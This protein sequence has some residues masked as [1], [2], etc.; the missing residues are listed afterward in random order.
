MDGISTYENYNRI[1]YQGWEAALYW[2]DRIGDLHY[3]VGGSLTT[4]RGKYLRYNENVVYDYQKVTGTATGS[5]RGYVCL[6]KFTSREEIETSPRQLF[7]DEV[8]V[9]DLKYADLNNDGL[10]DSN[11]QK[12]IGNS[13]PRFDYSVSI[14][15]RYRNFDFTIVG[16]GR[17]SYDTGLTN[18][19]FWNGG[20]RAPTRTSCATTS[21]ATIPV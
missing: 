17:A 6:G 12:V 21:A 10:I 2:S 19:Y 5:Y 8:Q 3:T 11:D 1:R 20:A 13:S 4:M 7:D 14:N 15:L 18:K 9:G 16:T